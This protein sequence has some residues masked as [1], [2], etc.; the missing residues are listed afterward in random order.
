MGVGVGCPLRPPEGSELIIPECQD[1]PGII[2]I[3]SLLDTHC[4]SLVRL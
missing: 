4:A 1:K 3:D 2:N